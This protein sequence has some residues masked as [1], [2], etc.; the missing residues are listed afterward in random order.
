[1]NNHPWLFPKHSR[2]PTLFFSSSL[3]QSHLW[4]QISLPQCGPQSMKWMASVFR[5]PL[6]CLTEGDLIMA[7]SMQKFHLPDNRLMAHAL[8]VSNGEEARGGGDSLTSVF[9]QGSARV[10]WVSPRSEQTCNWCSDI[11]CTT[12]T[13]QCCHCENLCWPFSRSGGETTGLLAF[14]FSSPAHSTPPSAVPPL[15]PPSRQDWVA[16]YERAWE[17]NCMVERIRF[18][19]FLPPSFL[20]GGGAPRWHPLS[21]WLSTPPQQSAWLVAHMSAPA[22]CLCCMLLRSVGHCFWFPRVLRHKGKTL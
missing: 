19:F 4:G 6:L 11:P 16:P 3:N 20:E 2:P 13:H 5:F 15:P 12:T 21:S 10:T 7:S 17:G 18:N 8:S 1:M 14:F 9:S 22:V